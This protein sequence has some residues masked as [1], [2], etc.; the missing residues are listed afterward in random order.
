[1][2]D[3]TPPWAL[4]SCQFTTCNG[5]A[6]VVSGLYEITERKRM[7]EELQHSEK[8]LKVRINNIPAVVHLKSVDGHYLLVNAQF[9][10]LYHTTSEQLIGKTAYD[11]LP[12]EAAEVLHTINEEVLQSRRTAQAEVSVQRP[13]GLHTYISSKFVLLDASDVPYAICGISID[14]TD[15]KQ[16][17]EALQRTALEHACHHLLRGA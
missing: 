6:V 5:E 10:R 14:I 15:R 9:E 12:K 3:D 17:E 13:D 8:L 2:V 16:A 1:M 4:C 7:E 11:I